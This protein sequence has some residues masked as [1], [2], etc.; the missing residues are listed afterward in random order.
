MKTK[1]LFY[2]L[3]IAGIF[4]FLVGSCKKK[5]D[6][7]AVEPP[8]VNPGELITTVRLIFTDSANSS[9]VTTATFNDPDGEGGNGPTQFDTI[10]L[11]ANKTYL[12]SVL[13]L[14]VTKSPVDTISNEV[15]EEAN[16]HMFFFTHTTVGI[17]TSY[18]DM[19]TNSPP[20]PVGL[21][22]KWVTGSAPANGI[23]QVILKHQ[24]GVKDGTS[25]PGDTDV[26]VSFPCKIQ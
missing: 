25:G 5:E 16:D 26:D 15:L 6:L 18:L 11:S 20:L 14:D 4:P 7:K 2:I 1:H 17:T 19:D 8:F 3:L 12:V 23:S 10:K 22:T 21:S 13:L 9:S 24:P